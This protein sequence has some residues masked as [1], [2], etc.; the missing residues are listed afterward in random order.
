MT[1]QSL[2]IGNQILANIDQIWT[3]ML[4]LFRF[5]GVFTIAPGIAASRQGM[6][7]RYAGVLSMAYAAFLGSPTAEIPDN[8]AAMFI[9]AMSEYALGFVLGLIPLL[10]VSGVQMAGGLSATTMGLGAAQLVDP[11]MGVNVST[12]G[13]LFG[14]LVAILFLLLGGHYVMLYAAAGM[15]GE[16]V[17]G[18]YFAGEITTDLLMDRS[19][20]MFRVGVM[21]SAPVIVALLLTQFVMGLIT[22]A[23]PQVNIFIVSFPL[24]IGIGLVLSALSLPE[25]LVFMER[26]IVGL[27]NSFIVVLQEASKFEPLTP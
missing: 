4:L 1:W 11:N 8:I 9:P 6:M 27:E 5:M 18:T 14:D 10:L 26:E 7:I 12:L 19:A 2:D 13:R 17:P 3:F 25:I 22:K 23:I 15:G 21:I 24:T 20:D 16:I